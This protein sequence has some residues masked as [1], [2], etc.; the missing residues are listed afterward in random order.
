[1]M[2]K[3]E[4]FESFKFNDWPADKYV[5]LARV[6]FFC[7]VIGL[8]QISAFLG[9]NPAVKQE[10][11]RQLAS[12]P[13]LAWNARSWISFPK[14]YESF[15][16]D[17]FNMRS[18]LIRVHS[19]LKYFVLHVSPLEQVTLGQNGWLFYSSA[20]DGDPLS[21]YRGTNLFSD[22]RLALMIRNLETWKKWFEKQGISYFILIAPD[23]Y[24]MYPENLPPWMRRVAPRTR[25]EQFMESVPPDIAE[26][27]VCPEDA[28]LEAKKRFPT[29]FKTD[30]HWN[31]WGAFIAAQSL[32]DTVSGAMPGRAPRQV[33]DYEITAGDRAGGDLAV[34]LGSS[35]R[36]RG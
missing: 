35:G 4:A 32:M 8:P 31:Q 13:T 21:C 20:K 30:T 25:L 33:S 36:H 10:E 11:K 23:K 28:L 34:M 12:F 1:M 14:S 9:W 24:S 18:W 26:I 2:R 27:M 16:L 22:K 3:I 15:F 17:R 29:Y 5:K 6:L 7:L 19:R